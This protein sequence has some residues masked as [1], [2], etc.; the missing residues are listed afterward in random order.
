MS[1]EKGLL[2]AQEKVSVTPEGLEHHEKALQEKKPHLGSATAPESGFH[3]LST[4]PSEQ[5]G[6]AHEGQSDAGCDP[7]ATDL[8]AGE[9][10]L[11]IKQH[12]KFLSDLG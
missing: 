5:V 10:K 8:P 1:H 11:S 9:G 3:F 7:P 6:R 2:K 12:L 4:I